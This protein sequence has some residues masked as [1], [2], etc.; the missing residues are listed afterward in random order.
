MLDRALPQ[1]ALFCDQINPQSE[2]LCCPA[3]NDIFVSTFMNSFYKYPPA[4]TTGLRQK[5][6]LFLTGKPIHMHFS[7]LCVSSPFFLCLQ[8]F[9]SAMTPYIF[10]QLF[11]FQFESDYFALTII[12]SELSLYT[13]LAIWRL[14]FSMRGFFSPSPIPHVWC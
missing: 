13:F 6:E 10:S 7:L 2:L 11:V 9:C 4:L 5:M 1:T 8:Y 12:V 3:T 14:F